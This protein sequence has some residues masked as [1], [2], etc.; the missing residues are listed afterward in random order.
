MRRSAGRFPEAGTRDGEVTVAEVWGL[1]SPTT[2]PDSGLEGAG[3][4]S[5]LGPHAGGA[6]K[7]ELG[8]IIVVVELIP[9]RK[10]Q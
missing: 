7:V 6:T 10:R 1:R 9:I 8:A 3:F 2:P 5:Q 4:D